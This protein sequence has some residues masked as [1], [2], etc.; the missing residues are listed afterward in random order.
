[1]KDHLPLKYGNFYLI[2]NLK[3]ILEKLKNTE[4]GQWEAH[5]FI[6][7]TSRNYSPLS[8]HKA[9]VRKEN[10][11]LGPSLNFPFFLILSIFHP[12]FF[13]PPVHLFSST[14]KRQETDWGKSKGLHS[15]KTSLEMLTASE[16][17]SS[18]EKS[19]YPSSETTD[20][21][22]FIPSYLQPALGYN[23]YVLNAQVLCNVNSGLMGKL[24]LCLYKFLYFIMFSGKQ[25]MD[26]DL[27]QGLL[28]CWWGAFS[29]LPSF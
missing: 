1:M 23:L 8:L 12:L 14:K 17:V 28:S 11:F 5:K 16:S 3:R 15:G 24:Y 13:I 22:T 21:T 2:K 19:T 10:T 26:T 9:L 4:K 6:N 25:W 18:K 27:A 29:F 7:K 20:T